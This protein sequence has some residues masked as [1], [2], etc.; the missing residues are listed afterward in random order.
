MQNYSPSPFWGTG[1]VSFRILAG[2]D[3]EIFLKDSRK[4]FPS[5]KPVLS[6]TSVTEYF[7]SFNSS[8]A[9]FK[10][11]FRNEICR[12]LAGQR[13]QFTVETGTAHI[14]ERA[15]YVHCEIGIIHV[16]LDMSLYIR[17]EFPVE[18]VGASGSCG[19]LFFCIDFQIRHISCA[20]MRGWQADWQCWLSVC[21]C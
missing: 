2:A 11:I 5:Q 19:G 10:R 17:H 21:L 1:S 13:F 9:C 12:C 20:A 4:Y 15:Q 14:Q 6:A 8:A 3:I 7:P 18:T 16:L